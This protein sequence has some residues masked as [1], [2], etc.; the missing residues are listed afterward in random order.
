MSM[1]SPGNATERMSSSGNRGSIDRTSTMQTTQYPPGA[2]IRRTVTAALAALFLLVPLVGT[3][4]DKGAG[5]HNRNWVDGPLPPVTSAA[6]YPVVVQ[7]IFI[8]MRD[9]TQLG[10]ALNLPQG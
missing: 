4:A 3:S 10:A 2:S 7:E 8:T 6:R 9:G 5:T 1:S